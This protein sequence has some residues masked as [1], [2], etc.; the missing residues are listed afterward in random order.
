M[1]DLRIQLYVTSNLKQNQDYLFVGPR[2]SFVFSKQV[3]VDHQLIH[4][5]SWCC[6]YICCLGSYSENAKL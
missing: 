2:K 4:K 1:L 3:M 5:V 6:L